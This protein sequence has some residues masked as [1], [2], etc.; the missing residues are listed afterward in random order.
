MTEVDL[1]DAQKRAQKQIE[2]FVRTEYGRI[3]AALIKQFGDIELAEE[4]LQ[5]ALVSALEKLT[6]NGEPERLD[7]WIFVTARRKALDIIRSD[8][9]RTRRHRLLGEIHASNT[10]SVRAEDEMK[11][12]IPDERLRLMYMCCHPALT[13]EAQIALVLR[14]VAGLS[15]GEIA[16]A[17][18]VAEST[19]AQ[20]LVR[21]KN[22]IREAGIPFSI[23]PADLKD[24]R[25]LAV[26]AVIYTIFNESYHATSGES[27]VR[28]DLAGEAIRLGKILAQLLP[29]EPEV[30]GLLSLMLLHHARVR[31]RVNTDG[32]IVQLDKQDRDLWDKSMIRR[33]TAIL[34]RAVA[35]RRRGPYQIQ[36]AIA[37][38]HANAIRPE[39]TDWVQIALLYEALSQMAP[40]PVV[41]LNRSAAIAMAYGPQAGIELMERRELSE[42][43]VDYMWYHS[44]LAEVYRKTGRLKDAR[45][46]YQRAIGLSGNNSEIEFLSRKIRELD[47]GKAAEDDAR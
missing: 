37:A 27:P 12:A 38:L 15:T 23:P 41:E 2:S 45:N 39:D 6:R 19:L 1:S 20:R 44:S 8:K 10:D 31:A 13:H 17:F 11:H 34:D 35:L 30:L 43:L 16:R 3:L 21:A 4:S 22:K 14:T 24:E 26:M 25:T 47:Q 18:L 9:A 32:E 33:G 5:E 36:A 28:H 40:S 42:A 7:A 29:S 46:A